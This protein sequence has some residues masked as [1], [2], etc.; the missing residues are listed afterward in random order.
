MAQTRS[1]S[2]QA[3]KAV[4][5]EARRQAASPLVQWLERLGFVTRGLIYFVIGVLAL[6]LA[7]GAG[8]A[9]ATPTSAI[10]VIGRQPFGKVFLVIIAVGLA[11]YALW[12]LVRA[13]FDPLGRGSGAK[14]LLARA[15]FLF[16]G[17]TYALLLIPTFL[18]LTGKPAGRIVAAGGGVPASLTSGPWGKWLVILIGVF[19]IAAGIGQL[20]VAANKRFLDDLKVNTMTREERET[21]TWFGQLGYA[22]RGIVFAMLGVLIL[23]PAL[24]VGAKPAP[25]FDAALATLAH[26]PYGEFTLGAVALGL[27]LFGLYSAMCAKWTRTGPRRVA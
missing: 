15:G 8:G 16:S 6:Q 17:I 1:M 22:A 10:E 2:K 26:G 3:G 20:A 12:G 18:A 11:G 19:W 14:G 21:A 24:T 5:S 9:T 23:Q 25:G 4:A 7:T 13:I 27:M